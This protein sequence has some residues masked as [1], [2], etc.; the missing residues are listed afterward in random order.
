MSEKKK[1]MVEE[2]EEGNELMTTRE[3]LNENGNDLSS[4]DISTFLQNDSIDKYGLDNIYHVQMNVME[5]RYDEVAKTTFQQLKEFH[6]NLLVNVELN[7]EEK[8]KSINI[9]SYVMIIENDFRRFL[10][11]INYFMIEKKD[12]FSEEIR[13]HFILLFQWMIKSNEKEMEN[14]DELSGMIQ[15]IFINFSLKLTDMD[16]IRLLLFENGM[17]NL[18]EMD[19]NESIRLIRVN[20]NVF[21][22]TCR[23]IIGQKRL[24]NFMTSHLFFQF[25]HFQLN[26]WKKCELIYEN[27]Q[28][29]YLLNC[30]ILED[31]FNFFQITFED[32]TELKNDT[33]LENYLEKNC[34]IILEH[35]FEMLTNLVHGEHGEECN[36]LILRIICVLIRYGRFLSNGKLVN[37]ME[38][39]YQHSSIQQMIDNE[40]IK[41]QYLLRRLMEDDNRLEIIKRNFEIIRQNITEN[42]D[43][44]QRLFY[45]VIFE[46][47]LSIINYSNGIFDY[48]KKLKEYSLTSIFLHQMKLLKGKKVLEFILENNLFFKFFKEA[49]DNQNHCDRYFD[50]YIIL[51]QLIDYFHEN[52]LQLS[53]MKQGISEEEMIMIDENNFSVLFQIFHWNESSIN[54]KIL[55]LQLLEM[56]SHLLSHYEEDLNGNELFRELL[57]PNFENFIRIYSTNQFNGKLL[58]FISNI[59][60]E[61][62][63]ILNDGD[64]RLIERDNWE[65]FRTNMF[66]RMNLR[67]DKRRNV[68][69]TDS[70]NMLTMLK[71]ACEHEWNL[72]VLLTGSE[73]EKVNQNFLKS[74]KHLFNEPLSTNVLNK[75]ASLLLSICEKIG[76]IKSKEDKLKHFISLKNISM[77]WPKLLMILESKCQWLTNNQRINCLSNTMKLLIYYRL[78]NRLNSIENNLIKFQRLV[79]YWLENLCKIEDIFHGGK[80]NDLIESFVYLFSNVPNEKNNSIIS[81]K[82]IQINLNNILQFLSI[83]LRSC[84]D[85]EY[86]EFVTLINNSIKLLFLQTIH[87]NGKSSILIDMTIVGKI[88][89]KLRELFFNRNSVTSNDEIHCNKFFISLNYLL[90][91]QQM[92]QIDWNNGETLELF[93][94][95]QRLLKRFLMERNDDTII[96][97]QFSQLFTLFI[98][99]N[100]ISSNNRHISPLINKKILYNFIEK[101]KTI[102]EKDLH[103]KF[104]EFNRRE[105]IVYYLSKFDEFST[106]LLEISARHEYSMEFLLNTFMSVTHLLHLPNII[107]EN[108]LN[109]HE[110]VEE[111]KNSVFSFKSD[112]LKELMILMGDYFNSADIVTELKIN[113]IVNWMKCIRIYMEIFN[114]VL[115]ELNIDN[116]LYSFAL[117]YNERLNEFIYF[118][119]NILQ[120]K[121]YVTEKNKV[122][123]YRFHQQNLSKDQSLNSNSFNVEIDKIE[124]MFISSHIIES[125]FSFLICLIQNLKLS[126]NILFP[127][128]DD[129]QIISNNK[130][131]NGFIQSIGYLLNQLEYT[132]SHLSTFN[133]VNPFDCLKSL[134]VICLEIFYFYLQLSPT[135][136]S[137]INEE[138]RRSY[139]HKKYLLIK[140][141]SENDHQRMFTTTS[142]SDNSHPIEVIDTIGIDKKSNLLNS[143]FLLCHIDASRTYDSHR[144]PSFGSLN[145]LIN[146]SQK[147]LIRSYTQDPSG[148]IPLQ[149]SKSSENQMKNKET[150]TVVRFQDENTNRTSQIKRTSS[151]TPVSSLII[152]VPIDSISG[153]F[154]SEFI[155]ISYLLFL[156]QI[157]V[158]LQVLRSYSFYTNY[159]NSTNLIILSGGVQQ[160][161]EVIQFDL[162]RELNQSTNSLM[163]LYRR[164]LSSKNS[165]SP[166]YAKQRG[167]STFRFST[168]LD[169]SKLKEID[170]LSLFFRFV[171]YF[172]KNFI[173]S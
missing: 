99:N 141:S 117:F 26:L 97:R 70:I 74:F 95:L 47:D 39:I 148:K 113:F 11:F 106:I 65:L 166:S 84:H 10:N 93:H 152:D 75:G 140:S 119:T 81:F 20:L 12:F 89:D 54:C 125:S 108:Y 24:R 21:L 150:K 8:F 134:M 103:L 161:Y 135:L 9:I 101:A 77:I 85:M 36:E 62:F 94:P 109:S 53:I 154:L 6:E 146:F 159:K 112:I 102:L 124:E 122:K 27:F 78:L 100:D 58:G 145:N 64:G 171:N 37:Q 38:S 34:S 31:W 114:E 91:N 131:N 153:S 80:M 136:Q 139:F 73:N 110:N 143:I 42:N 49:K 105:L 92:K 104:K 52:V 25:S 45:C 46:K 3:K 23:I 40:G 138:N 57:L 173:Q 30:E 43:E 61:T 48:E 22:K 133:E 87:S 88:V 111:K 68:P 16:C 123:N 149:E 170:E 86:G 155:E 160:C 55:R 56:I 128:L 162:S 69:F 132:I 158:Y 14:D 156:S 115:R 13:C 165:R 71:M 164:S 157:S 44:V 7:D 5:R 147:L 33:K 127:S 126:S 151:V 168:S 137:F 32:S 167:T 172:Q 107:N 96:Y 76:R 2:E 82:I 4:D 28:H 169:D 142:Q 130:Y 29:F 1:R 50:C 17:M 18:E 66:N 59:L 63:S 83:I 121:F 79:N 51:F 129:N 120:L 116:Y 163:R 118:L 144:F 90:K 72:F 35:L 67:D 60:I 41:L 15:N 98:S 19:L